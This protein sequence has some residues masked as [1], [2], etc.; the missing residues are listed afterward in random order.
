MIDTVALGSL[1]KISTKR[2]AIARLPDLIGGLL[3]QVNA[4]E[5]CLPLP[6]KL[7]TVT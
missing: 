6:R 1:P 5:V 3:T 4:V 7:I 2:I